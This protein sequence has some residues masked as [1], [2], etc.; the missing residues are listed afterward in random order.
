MPKCLWSGWKWQRGFKHVASPFACCSVNCECLRKKTQ[1]EKRNLQAKKLE[2]LRWRV[3]KVYVDNYVTID[4]EKF[5]KELISD[6]RWM[7]NVD[8]F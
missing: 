2:M 6:L 1:I 7:W 5:H 3:G 4:L 8:K